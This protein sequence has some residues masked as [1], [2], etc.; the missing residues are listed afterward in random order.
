MK[1][2]KI[3]VLALSMVL[4]VTACS[5]AKN[6]PT[7]EP[8]LKMEIQGI[9]WLWERFDDTVD[10]ND[11]VV[12][13]PNLYTLLLN[14]DG[15]YEVKADCNLAR[16]QYTLE[17]SN[18]TFQPGPATL[19]ECEEGSLYNIYLTQLGTVMTFVMDGNNLILTLSVDAGNMV[20][21]PA[22]Q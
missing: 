21:V 17:D 5:S 15:T 11:I 22:A 16:G 1:A 18:V 20:F 10:T 7:D 3:V 4:L 6:Q 9:T 19:A 14:P 12:N 2:Q 13:D 8:A